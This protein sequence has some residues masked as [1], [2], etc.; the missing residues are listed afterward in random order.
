MLEAEVLF[1]IFAKIPGTA[2]EETVV[3]KSAR[4]FKD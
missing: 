4:G 3:A 2:A 1:S